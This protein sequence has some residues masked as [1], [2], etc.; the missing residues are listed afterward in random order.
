MDPL[1]D[2]E[3]ADP[4]EHWE[5]LE[6]R[7]PVS[8]SPPPGSEEDSDE[9]WEPPQKKR[10]VSSSPCPVSSASTAPTSTPVRPSRG[11]PSRGVKRPAQKQR[12]ASTTEGEERW[13]TVLEDDVEPRQPTFCPKRQPGPQ[14]DMTGRYS[15]L[16]LFQLFFT[17]SVVATLVTNTNKHGA[18]KQAGKKDPWRPISMNDMY[19]FFS[20]V[21]FMGLVKVSAF[22]KYWNGLHK[23]S[24]FLHL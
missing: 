22:H 1:L 10:P 16:Q 6:K 7:W 18:K 4:E 21:I 24:V 9:H 12:D 15:P 20:M 17:S 2:R 13:H 11:V 23:S 14:L 19:S 3:E 8:S 5:P